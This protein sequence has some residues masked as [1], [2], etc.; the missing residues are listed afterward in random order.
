MQ[1]HLRQSGKMFRGYLQCKCLLICHGIRTCLVIKLYL[2]VAKLQIGNGIVLEAPASSL[3]RFKCATGSVIKALLGSL[4]LQE[5]VHS[6][7]GDWERD[8]IQRG[9]QLS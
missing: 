5:Q 1:H 2:L 7:A 9:V 3:V 6:Q 4:S 8:Y